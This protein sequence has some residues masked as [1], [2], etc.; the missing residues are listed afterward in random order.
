MQEI[1]SKGY[2]KELQ[3]T[4]NDGREC[5]LPHHG[6]YHPI[7]FDSSAEFNG[8]SI[9][10]ELIRG[11]DL[12]T[13]FCSNSKRVLLSI[14]EEHRKA[15][16]KNEDLLGSLLEEQVLGVLWKTEEDILQFKVSIKDKPTTRREILSILSSIYD[17]LGFETP[18][19][20]R[21]KHILQK[22][23]KKN[24]KWD[25]K[26]PEDLQTEREKWKIKLLALQ[27]VH[28]KRCFPRPDFEKVSECRL[29]H[30]SN[31]CG[32]GYGQASYLRRVDE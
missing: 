3:A 24:Q 16:I 11:P 8:R 19:L 32:S 17:P 25:T 1:I 14:F 12:A 13:K 18:F 6:V 15:S 22:L 23:C 5:Y 31:A 2:A 30:F 7:V 26:L 28:I 10:T 9:K 21:G 4:L 29:H 20:L 27:E